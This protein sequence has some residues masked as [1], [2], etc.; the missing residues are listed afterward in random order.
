MAIFVPYSASRE[1]LAM[2]GEEA[3]KQMVA[4]LKEKKTVLEERLREKIEALKDLCI[5]EAVRFTNHQLG[6]LIL[7][8]T[9]NIEHR[10]ATRVTT[11]CR[12]AI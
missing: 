10:H 6:Y 9:L 7:W 3:R 1:L 11:C 8:F 5:R 2:E 4:A 12:V